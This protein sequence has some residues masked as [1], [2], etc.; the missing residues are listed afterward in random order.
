[1]MLLVV[2]LPRMKPPIR[3]LSPVS[4]RARVEMLRSASPEAVG[5]GVADGLGVGVMLGTGVALGVGVTDG[6]GV[7][8]GVGGMLGVG[9]TEGV[10]VTLGVG[11]IVALGEGVGVRD[12]VGVIVCAVDSDT[13]EIAQTSTTTSSHFRT[14]G[15]LIGSELR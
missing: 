5:V 7:M 15:T 6:V 4:A 12:G 2:P 8:L 13:S 3:T 10:G 14:R 1:M 9:V 11:L